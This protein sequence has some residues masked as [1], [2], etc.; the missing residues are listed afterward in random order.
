MAL[1]GENDVMRIL[2]AIIMIFGACFALFIG[3]L[4]VVRDL[5]VITSGDAH[6]ELNSHATGRG[7]SAICAKVSENAQ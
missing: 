4:S 7:E 5:L 3:L 2:V 1:C 6:P